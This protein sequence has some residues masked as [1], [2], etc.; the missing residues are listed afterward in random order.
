MTAAHPF[1]SI[2]VPCC[3]VEPYVRECFESVLS[4]SFSDWELLAMVETS[5]DRTEEIVRGFASRD[6]RIRVFTGPRTGSCSVPRNRGIELARGAHLVFLDGDDFI[7]PGC[8]QRIRDAIAAR[9]GADLYPCAIQVR[10]DLAGQ[11][12]EL[13]DNYPTDAPPELTGPAATLLVY[14][15]KRANPNPQLQ[16]TVFR[17]EF[18][19]ENGLRCVPGLRRQ[20]SEFSP[21][22]LYLARR[23]VPLHEPYYIYRLQPSSVG[24]SARGA[25]HFHSDWAII[26][27]SLFAFHAQVSRDASFDPRIA[28]WWRRQWLSWLFYFWFSPGN[29]RS[30][31]RA[32]RI[33]TLSALFAGGFGDFKAL[34]RA[35]TLRQRL[36]GRAVC[37]YVRHPLL[38]PAIERLFAMVF[39]SARRP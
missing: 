17:R 11:N 7:V 9:P 31:P 2:V 8:L 33:E 6:P 24:S 25:G 15:H 37:A 30:I 18:L 23:V 19:L 3:N 38:R 39:P 20:D 35:A 10:D 28:V 21:R 4:Q 14:R 13:R 29:V 1:F 16:L 27:R 26:L 34:L 12:G 22:A 5:S 32:R 36:P